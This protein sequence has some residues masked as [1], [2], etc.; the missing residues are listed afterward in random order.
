MC[1]W[2]Y[3][4][5]F[6]LLGKYHTQNTKVH[7]QSMNTVINLSFVFDWKSVVHNCVVYIARIYLRI[8]KVCVHFH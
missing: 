4:P 8:N 6:V 3:M 7:H 1:L 2:L 5:M